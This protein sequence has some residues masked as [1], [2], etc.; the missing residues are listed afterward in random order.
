MARAGPGSWSRS[1]PVTRRRISAAV[2][3]MGPWN[4]GVV[5][6]IGPRWGRRGGSAGQDEG[7]GEHG[8]VTPYSGP[9]SPGSGEAAGAGGLL[10]DQR[11]DGDV[12]PVDAVEV[13]HHQLRVLPHP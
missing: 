2:S 3:A 13:E 1:G 9:P 11:A 10:L 5:P 4:V 8:R 12:R 6:G 7:E